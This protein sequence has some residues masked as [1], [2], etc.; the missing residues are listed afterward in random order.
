MLNKISLKARLILLTVIAVLLFILVAVV[1]LVGISNLNK[2]LED[3]YKEHMVPANLLDS[4]F[5]DINNNRT[6]LLRPVKKPPS[7]LPIPVKV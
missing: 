4:I 5:A 1:G 2:A 7:S 6:Q 3:V